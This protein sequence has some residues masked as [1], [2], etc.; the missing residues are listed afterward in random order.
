MMTKR[1]RCPWKKGMVDHT[2]WGHWQSLANLE[3]V[4]V[5]KVAVPEGNEGDLKTIW[6]APRM[7]RAVIMMAQAMERYGHT[8]TEPFDNDG[9][10]MDAIYE[11]KKCASLFRN[12][13]RGKTR[14]TT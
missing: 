7:K 2:P 4:T 11:V 9:E 6:E 14:K 13:P 3:G 1:Y 5:A 10:M 12:N 8:F